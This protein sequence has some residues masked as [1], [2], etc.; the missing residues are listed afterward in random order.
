MRGEYLYTRSH[1]YSNLKAIECSR[2][3]YLHFWTG[4]RKP[5][6]PAR[7]NPDN[8]QNSELR[9]DLGTLDLCSVCFS[10]DIP[11]QTEFYRLI[12]FFVCDLVNR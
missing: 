7:G 6:N 5:E 3:T 4:E 1:T 2:S 9:V 10:Y 12:I 11:S 8:M